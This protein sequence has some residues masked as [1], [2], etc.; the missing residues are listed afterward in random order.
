MVSL[1]HRIDGIA[2]TGDGWTIFCRARDWVARGLSA[3]ADRSLFAGAMSKGHAMTGS[4][5]D[6]LI[7]PEAAI[8]DTANLA[9]T[10]TTSFLPARDTLL[11]FAKETLP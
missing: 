10:T 9:D 2:Q 11:T 8:A 6:W 4:R 5:I 3:I 1:F 7:G